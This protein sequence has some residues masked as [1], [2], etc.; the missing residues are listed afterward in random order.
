MNQLGKFFFLSFI[1]RLVFESR[2]LYLWRDLG[3]SGFREKLKLVYLVCKTTV[4]SLGFACRLLIG[5][6]STN[7]G[8]MIF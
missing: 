2:D 6:S 8:S 4:V 1:K 7:V 5:I 3:K